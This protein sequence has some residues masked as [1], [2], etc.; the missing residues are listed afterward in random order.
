M[1]NNRQDI[2]D[3]DMTHGRS[4]FMIYFLKIKKLN[5]NF[6]FFLLQLIYSVLSI[7]TVQESD[8]VIYTHS[9]SHIIF[10]HVPSQ[11]TRYSFLCYTTQP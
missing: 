1:V 3:E 7:S 2:S 8:P 5:W 10:H 11:V 4:F 9:F 6:L